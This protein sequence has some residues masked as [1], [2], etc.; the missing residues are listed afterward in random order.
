MDL[1]VYAIQGA[2]R[3]VGEEPIAVSAQAFNFDKEH[4]KGIHESVL[5]AIRVSRRCCC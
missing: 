4:F 5:L 1:G 3:I 2:R